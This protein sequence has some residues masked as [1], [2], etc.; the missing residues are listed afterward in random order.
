[1]PSEVRNRGIAP[2]FVILGSVLFVHGLLL[3]NDGIY[4]DDWL[5]M[6]PTDRSLN[7]PNIAA[8]F[9]EM[10][11]LPT[12]WLHLWLFGLV[13]YRI[14]VFV[15]IGASAILLYMICQDSE[16][17]N[18][19]ES[20]VIALMSVSYPAFQT[21]VVLSTANYVF[22]YALFLLAAWLL[23]RAERV[24]GSRHAALRASGLVILFLSFNLISL[25]VFYFGL[26][27][28]VLFE[29]Q[30][31]QA[32]PWRQGLGRFALG[33]MDYVL[34]PFIFWVV[35]ETFFPR[36]GLY[37][38]Y[39]RFQLSLGTFFLNCGL[40]LRFAIY[41][42]LNQALKALLEQPAFA[43]ATVLV[44]CWIYVALKIGSTE[45]FENNLKP[46]VLLLFG[47]FLL[48]LGIFPY[49]AVGLGPT[50]HGWSTRH[51]L[52]VGLPMGLIILGVARFCFAGAEGALR[53]LAFA[54]LVVLITAFSLSTIDTYISWQARWVKDRSII[55]NL[56]TL[57]EFKRF[58]VF[59]I[60]DQYE[61]GG[62]DPYDFYEWSSIFKVVSKDMSRIGL[63]RRYY[64]ANFLT[65]GRRY[66]NDRYNLSKFDPSGCQARLLIRRGRLA[67]SDF[68]LSG[69]YL[70]YKFL[71]PSRMSQFL[72]GVT[73]IQVQA[74]ADGVGNNCSGD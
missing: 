52:L 1:M 66:F 42:Q 4:W 14:V 63:D 57:G 13:D 8:A 53:Q 3:L 7:W 5:W 45:F 70:L 50:L 2:Y 16:Y 10:G 22:Y 59:W 15:C 30:R 12:N 55:T 41:G 56:G 33:R 64:D 43:L 29:R 25:L 67:Y 71:W 68:K 72:A 31:L 40:F 65:D 37:A 21:W 23:L 60:D 18:R 27:A 62:E 44:A 6:N 11:F 49:A 48:G 20:L 58:S 24:V 34:M 73:E 35:R 39:T 36:H 61:L 19:M 26:L 32:L 28:M 38:D 17:L 9:N 54:L 51:A 69:R 74:M 47:I 46:H